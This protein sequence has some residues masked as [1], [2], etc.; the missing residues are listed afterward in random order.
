VE[1]V[2]VQLS[3]IRVGAFNRALAMSLLVVEMRDQDQCNV[4]AKHR[5]WTVS[6]EMKNI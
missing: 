2:G 3:S 4:L 1:L 6:G 5:H